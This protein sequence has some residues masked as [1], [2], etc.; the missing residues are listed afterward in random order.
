MVN[1]VGQ[2]VNQVGPSAPVEIT[3]LQDVP[4]AGDQF[5]AFA[6]EK[7]ARQIG[8]ARQQ[9]RIDEN[10]GGQST[11]SLDDLFEKKL[12]KVK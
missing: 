2:R 10:R 5:L 1:D 4:Q 8:I 3:G 6:D 9:K 12:S 11:V 7:K